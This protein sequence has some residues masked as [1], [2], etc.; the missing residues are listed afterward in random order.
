MTIPCHCPS[1]YMFP[2]SYALKQNRDKDRKK[3]KSV[4]IRVQRIEKKI[5]FREKH[6]LNKCH[7]ENSSSV[8]GPACDGT[9]KTYPAREKRVRLKSLEW[10]SVKSVFVSH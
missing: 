5:T 9:T 10:V 1:I 3:Q 2:S 8:T 7:M 6:P 4:L